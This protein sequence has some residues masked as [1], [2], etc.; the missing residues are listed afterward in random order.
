MKPKTKKVKKKR[1]LTL[2]NMAMILM[3]TV[4]LVLILKFPEV[5][6]EYINRGLKL[7]VSTVIPSLFPFMVVSELIV[8]SGF[9]ESMGRIF[10]KPARLLFGISGEGASAFLLGTLCGFPIGTRVAISLYE[11]G[12]ISRDELSRLVCFSNNPSSAFVISAI[13]AT[14]FGCREFGVALYFITIVS[15]LI[16]GMIQ[17]LLLPSDITV[18][19][20]KSTKERK[21]QGGIA[22]FSEA[23]SS[24]ALSMLKI[25]AFIVFF[26]SF[27]GVV[28]VL[29]SHFGASQSARALLFSFFELTCGA[30]EA[31]GISEISVAVLVAAFAVG[32]SGLSMHFQMI[33]LCNGIRIPFTRYFLA[34]L[35]EGLLNV[36]FVF[37]Y[38]K[39]F[40]SELYF[41]A[42][43]VGVFYMFDSS[44]GVLSITVSTIFFLSLGVTVLKNR[45]R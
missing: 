37:L 5:S 44:I 7:C 13:G 29:L 14:L 33:G 36:A 31:A 12:N 25:C 11:R 16:V 26:S 27:T 32:W 35:S 19:T 40:S 20:C 1:E 2:G 17:N 10:K 45:I 43:S 6:I 34:K 21:G 22:V 24:S 3:S 18:D 8:G 39:R 15:S 38:F 4:S 42:Q 23:V 28:G 30:S 9:S 41:D